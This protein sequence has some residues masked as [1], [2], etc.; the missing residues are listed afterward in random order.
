VKCYSSLYGKPVRTIPGGINQRVAPL[1][2]G[3]GAQLILG[4]GHVCKT[5]KLRPAKTGAS[6]LQLFATR[7]YGHGTGAGPPNHIQFTR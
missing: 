1:C 3:P 6:A 7:D 4:Q 5:T 2:G